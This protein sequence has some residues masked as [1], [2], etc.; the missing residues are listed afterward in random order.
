MKFIIVANPRSGTHLLG[1]FLNSHPEL[2]CYDELFTFDHP[3]RQLVLPYKKIKN[4][5]DIEDGEGFIVM[6]RQIIN[7][8]EIVRGFKVIHLIRDLRKNA[9]SYYIS[10]HRIKLGLGIEAKPHYHY[11]E[12]KPDM[13]DLKISEASIGRMARRIKGRRKIAMS[14]INCPV[15]EVSYEYLCQNKSVPSLS[16]EKAKPI[17]DFLGVRPMKLTTSLVKVLGPAL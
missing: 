7:L 3:K 15:L 6:Y 10:Y 14:H 8:G 16:E 17:C 12:K 1:T 5:Q 11:W 4:I 9:I 13:K 2:K